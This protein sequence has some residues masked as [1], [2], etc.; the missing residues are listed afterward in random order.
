[1]A[2][3]TSE[4]GPRVPRKAKTILNSLVGSRSMTTEGMEWLICATDPFHDDRVRC[5]GYPDLSTVNSVAQVYTTTSSIAGPV[6]G[7]QAW[8]LHIPFIPVQLLIRY[9]VVV[10]ELQSK[11]TRS[12]EAE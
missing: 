3:A 2:N 11:H 12:M 1:M 4:L 9:L 5:P 6:G 8:D 7:T 10:H